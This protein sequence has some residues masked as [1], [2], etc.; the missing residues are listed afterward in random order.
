MQAVAKA[1][2][3]GS[4]RWYEPELDLVPLAVRDGETAIDVGANFG[5]YAHHLSRAVG[6]T[7]RVYAFEPVP[8]TVDTFRVIARLLRFRNVELVPKGCGEGSGRI[9]FR[10]PV[11]PS[12]AI[13][14]GLTHLAA[15][16][17]D[18]PGKETQ[19]RWSETREIQCEVVALDDALPDIERLA[20]LKCDIEGGELFALRGAR[21]LIDRHRP[22][23]LLE[24]NPWY[25]DGLGVRVEDLTGFFFERDYGLY[26]YDVAG[27]RKRLSACPAAEIMERNY[28][29]IHPDRRDRF[30]SVLAASA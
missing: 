5:V 26:R 8:F 10:V 7:G 18:R 11:Q 22:T 21:R 17:D 13:S 20:F 6:R 19:V 15:R 12:G 23:V 24:I 9:A 30:A 27:G 3:I 2:D 25:L 16:N 14:T 28:V 4:G 29:F 1:W